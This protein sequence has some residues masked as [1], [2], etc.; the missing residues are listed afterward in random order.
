[1]NQSNKL[2]SDIVAFRTYA[3]Y[4]PNFAR[5]ESLEETI[6]RKMIMDLDK[7]GSLS[8]SIS[9]SI[10]KAY[11]NVHDLKV[12]PSMR[13]L[14]FAGEAVLK[15]PVRQYNCFVESTEF[16]TDQGIKSFK[17][18]K[19]GDFVNVLSYRGFKKAKIKKFGEEEIISLLVG[20]GRRKKEILTTKNHRWVVTDGHA[21]KEVTTENLKNGDVLVRSHKGNRSP[22]LKACRIGI[23]HGIV[24][25][26]G[27]TENDESTTITL[28]GDSTQL[29]EYINSGIMVERGIN[30]GKVDEKIIHKNLPYFYKTLPSIKANKEYLLGFMMGWFAADGSIEKSDSSIALD[31]ASLDNLQ[32]ARGVLAKLNIFTND[33]KLL[34][35]TSPFDGSDKPLYRLLINTEDLFKDFFLKKEHNQRY[36]QTE[37][38]FPNYKV[39]SVDNTGFVQPVWC[40]Q[41]PKTETFTLSYGIVTKNCSYLPID[42]VRSFG[43]SLFLLLS[44]TGVGFSC[45]SR[46]VSQLPIIKMP[47]EEGTFV[48]HDS[49]EGWA[50][51]VD[52]LFESY[53]YGRIR[54]IFDFSKIRP[55]GSYLVTTGAKAPGPEP[56]KSMLDV[57]E[58]LLKNSVGRKLKPI[59]VHDI[60][61]IIS[62]C[63]LAGGIRRAALISLF[64]KD[65]EEMLNCKKG[66]WWVKH[67]H[68]AR[69][70]NSA[71]LVRG[72][73]TKEEFFYI[74]TKCQESNSGE[75]GFFW[76]NDPDVGTN[77]CCEI[78]L[79]PNQFCNLTTINQTGIK[80]KKDF[81]SRVYSATVLGTL[82]AAYTDFHYL[83][84]KWRI[85][86]EAESLIGVSFTGI[87][88]GNGIVTAEW[89]RDGAKLAKEVNEKYAK[90]LGINPAARVTAV[91]P[92]GTSSCVLGSSSGIHAR[93]SKYYLRRVRMNKDDALATYLSNVIPELVEDDLSSS[94]GVVVTIPQESPDNSVTREKETAQSALKRVLMYNRNWVRPGYRSGANHH[95]VSCTINVKDEEWSELRGSMWDSRDIYSGISLLPYDGGSYKQSPFESCDK[96]TF[97]K[98]NSMVKEIDLK[99]V[100]ET[101]DNTN[102][103]E[104]VACSGG[105]C[106]VV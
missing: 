105:I 103:M 98:Y 101:D 78:S 36:G 20:K 86:T 21:Q 12:M 31:C 9:K 88:D 5:R 59:E 76:T 22:K 42:N 67:P 80:D 63:V 15:N 55:K 53:M 25:G 93:F 2:L 33:I 77:P 19:D 90:K 56:L 41:E 85:Q 65:N 24:F 69:A 70:N 106:D 83:R 44:G 27:F 18:F 30:G 35:K 82:Q 54:P 16:V 8:K 66:E 51:S 71:V 92:E 50:Q 39:I 45:Q 11:E 96:E 57:V 84:D 37:D 17:D 91:K 58:K 7:F 74:F 104:M 6:N 100:R 23:E 79:N 47:K 4:L 81:L 38:K 40:V 52:V 34:R 95:N 89:L 3:K 102:R 62:D 48:V 99:N 29:T 14:Q 68:R 28:F 87:A 49:I 61:C 32:F 94:T 72:E 46:Y 13:G 10:I 26:D 60:V 73:V 64:D 75:P 1:M 43:E 97:D